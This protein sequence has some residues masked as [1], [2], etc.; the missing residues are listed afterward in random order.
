MFDGLAVVCS[1]L[2]GSMW[3]STGWK[4]IDVPSGVVS[5]MYSDTAVQDAGYHKIWDTPAVLALPWIRE[6]RDIRRGRYI[7]PCL[8]LDRTVSL[9]ALKA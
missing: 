9:A 5:G 3:G 2:W 6:A 4:V 1:P 7:N 8:Y